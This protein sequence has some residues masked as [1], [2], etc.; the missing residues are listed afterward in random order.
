LFSK[1]LKILSERRV[2]VTK[3]WLKTICQETLFHP[4]YPRFVDLFEFD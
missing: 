2:S 3:D 1:L 4:L